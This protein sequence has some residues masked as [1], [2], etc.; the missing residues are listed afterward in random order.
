MMTRVQDFALR[1][2]SASVIGRSGLKVS[3]SSFSLYSNHWA[4]ALRTLIVERFLALVPLAS[5]ARNATA[6]GMFRAG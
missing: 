6:A 4:A 1:I 5:M 3:Y 2:K